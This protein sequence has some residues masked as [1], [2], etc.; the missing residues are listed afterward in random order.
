MHIPPINVLHKLL[1]ELTYSFNLIRNTLDTSYGVLTINQKNIVAVLSLNASGALFLSKVNF[2]EF[3]E[4]NKEVYRNFQ[5][6]TLK[7]LTDL[8]T[9]IGVDRDE[10]QLMLKRAFIIYIQMLFLLPTTINKISPIHMPLIFHVD[11]IREWNWGGHIFD[12]LIKGI[13]EHG[14]VKRVELKEKLTRIQKEEKKEKKKKTQK[15]K[16][17]SSKSDSGTSSESDSEQ[18]SK[19]PPK[20]RKQPTRKIKKTEQ[21]QEFLREAKKNAKPEKGEQEESYNDPAQEKM[22]VLQKEIHSQSELLSITAQSHQPA[23]NTPTA[24]AAPSKMTSSFVKLE[25]PALSF[26]FG[27]LNRTRRYTDLGGSID[28]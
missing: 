4:E 28:N 16:D 18:D 6:K 27:F 9:K 22:I 14:I 23:E 17:I 1:K 24:P 21:T 5:G 26:N 2:K 19:E 12:F 15:K 10:D 3:I 20:A 25:F 13:S 8:I 11:T 7:Q